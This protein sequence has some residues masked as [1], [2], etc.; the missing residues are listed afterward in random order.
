MQNENTYTVPV[1]SSGERS[2]M[3]VN[4]KNLMLFLVFP[5]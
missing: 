3:L 2:S 1:P 4:R 5:A